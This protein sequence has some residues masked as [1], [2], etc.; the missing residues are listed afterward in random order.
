M[1][2]DKVETRWDKLI[3]E[4]YASTP[5]LDTY[6]TIIPVDVVKRGLDRF[7]KNPTVYVG[8][9]TSKPV[10]NA[11]DWSVDDKGWRVTVEVTKNTDDVMTDIRNGLTKWFSIGF[12]PDGWVYIDTRDGRPLAELTD[13]EI[14]E[15]PHQKIW[16]RFTEIEIRELSIVNAPSN[17]DSLFTM[18][19][20]LNMFFSEAEIRSVA[21][22]KRV[23]ISDD[24]NPFMDSK[25]ED[26]EEQDKKDYKDDKEDKDDKTPDSDKKQGSDDESDKEEAG[27][28]DKKEDKE[29]K[30]DKK[31]DK[32]EEKEDK[33]EDKSDDTKKDTDENS[34]IAQEDE[35]DDDGWN[36]DESSSDDSE[37]QDKADDRSLEVQLEEQRSLTNEA[38]ELAW[39]LSDEITV[40]RKRLAKTPVNRPLKWN[41]AESRDVD[42]LLA[43]M[44]KAK[45]RA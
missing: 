16:R 11:T 27:S 31:E 30:E 28:K 32:E 3:I 13:D 33:E 36:D 35:S 26:K 37:S 7:R 39:Q 17:P 5:S 38:I 40:L 41:F 2:F 19:R 42:P 1:S 20:A 15:I 4:W 6:N 43:D 44:R 12:M 22:A 29:D 24:Q 23:L 25:K 10:W 18:K 21:K 34:D 9:D 8:H 45:E 14:E